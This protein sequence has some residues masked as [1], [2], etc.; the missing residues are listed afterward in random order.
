MRDASDA[1]FR[2]TAIRGCSVFFPIFRTHQLHMMNQE[3]TDYDEAKDIRIEG[4]IIIGRG[5]GGQAPLA[6]SNTSMGA[7]FV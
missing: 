6:P 2:H 3:Q 4:L 7:I 1:I 5:S